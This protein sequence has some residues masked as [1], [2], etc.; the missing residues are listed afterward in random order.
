MT[1]RLHKRSRKKTDYNRQKQ[2]RKHKHQ[3]NRNDY[4][5]KMRKKTIQWTL[6]STKKRNITGENLDMTKKEKPNLSG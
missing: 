6:H 1:P 5:T 4:K 2:Y 3:L